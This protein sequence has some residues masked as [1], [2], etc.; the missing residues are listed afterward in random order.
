VQEKQVKIDS[1]DIIQSPFMQIEFIEPEKT[2][3][4]VKKKELE[5]VDRL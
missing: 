5:L 4:G 3:L 2:E 1:Q